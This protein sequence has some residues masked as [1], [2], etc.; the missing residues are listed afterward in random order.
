MKTW[1]DISLKK[2][3]ALMNVKEEGKEAIDL[4]IE[5]IAI[6]EDK[7]F[8]EVENNTPEYIFSK[9]ESYSWVK[10]LP[11]AK[12]VET[13]KVDGNE[14]GLTALNELTLAQ[15]VDIE[16]YYKL[17]FDD[18]IENIISILVLPVKSRNLLTRKYELEPYKFDEDRVKIMLELNMEFVWSNILFFWNGVERYTEDLRDYLGLMT[19]G[20]VTPMKSYSELLMKIAEWIKK[21]GPYRTLKP[22]T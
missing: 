8:S 5:Q 22:T 13:I 6:I 18:N 20:K 21:E 3:K 12:R 9:W 10:N 19:E 17:G 16:E 2:A 14:Y 1:K 4:L 15:M 11:K 7:S